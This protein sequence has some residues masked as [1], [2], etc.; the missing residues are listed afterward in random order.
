MVRIR[1]RGRFGRE[2]CSSMVGVPTYTEKDE[3]VLAV[4]NV[5]RLDRDLTANAQDGSPDVT[6]MLAVLLREEAFQMNS[7]FRE[8]TILSAS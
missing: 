4:E 1:S 5:E 6:R 8:S 7:T 3:V 2:K